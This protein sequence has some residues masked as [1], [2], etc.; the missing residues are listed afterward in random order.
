MADSLLRAVDRY[1]ETHADENGIALTPVRG[2]LFIRVATPSKLVRDPTNPLVCLVLQGRK[3]VIVGAHAYTLAA[4]DSMLVAS[5]AHGNRR[6]KPLGKPKTQFFPFRTQEVPLRQTMDLQS[7]DRSP[8]NPPSQSTATTVSA[9]NHSPDET[10]PT[11]LMNFRPPS[12]NSLIDETPPACAHLPIH[13]HRPSRW[14]LLGGESAEFA[15]S[16]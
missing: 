2:F 6:C 3:R 7:S 16:G 14:H 10:P 12:G 8:F 11:S 4:G 9:S 15:I 1:A 5:T 13:T